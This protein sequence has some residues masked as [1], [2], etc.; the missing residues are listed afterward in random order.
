MLSLERRIAEAV[1][2]QRA[3][4]AE[5]K[6]AADGGEGTHPAQTLSAADDDEGEGALSKK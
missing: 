1:D 6:S 5:A 2:L 4:Q 3:S